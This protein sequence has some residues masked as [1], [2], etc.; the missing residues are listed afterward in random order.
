MHCIEY[1]FANNV[2]VESEKDEP[3]NKI[4]RLRFSFV[5]V[6][7]NEERVIMKYGWSYYFHQLNSRWFTAGDCMEDAPFLLSP[8][9]KNRWMYFE[10]TLVR[11]IVAL[12]L[13]LFHAPNDNE[14]QCIFLP[15]FLYWLIFAIF[16]FLS[17]HP[18]WRNKKFALFPC[19]VAIKVGH[20]NLPT[21]LTA[22]F[23]INWLWS[24]MTIPFLSQF[25]IKKLQSD[26]FSLWVDDQQRL[27]FL[28]LPQFQVCQVK[29]KF[30][31]K[32]G[33][34]KKKLKRFSTPF[35]LRKNG[36]RMESSGVKWYIK[37]LCHAHF[38]TGK[39]SLVQLHPF[40]TFFF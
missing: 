11:H 8:L 35:S 25:T 40:A 33:L 17:F 15:H 3:L 10:Q 23:Q 27:V 22:R 14:A 7:L 12:E 5:N 30:V 9:W 24:N 32:P 39:M 36:K 21:W 16:C 38:I 31:L 6:H 19:Q 18:S 20:K 13:L 2:P 28:K 1:L 26:M 37:Y 4:S 29:P 34:A